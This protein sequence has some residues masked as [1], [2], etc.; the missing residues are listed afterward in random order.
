MS[1]EQPHRER[2]LGSTELWSL[3]GSTAVMPK[4]DNRW[5][6][7]LRSAWWTRLWADLR[8]HCRCGGVGSPVAHLGSCPA[9]DEELLPMIEAEG[10]R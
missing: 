8:G 2:I 10:R 1:A 3:A 5:S 6:N 4:L 7:D 9:A